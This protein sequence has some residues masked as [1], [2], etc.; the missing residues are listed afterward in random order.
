MIDMD[1]DK[2]Q[3]TQVHEHF[4][5]APFRIRLASQLGLVGVSK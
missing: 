4:E 5:E 2:A 1:T 3:C